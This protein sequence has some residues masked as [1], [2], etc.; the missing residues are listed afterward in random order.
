MDNFVWWFIVI[1]CLFPIWGA[2][3]WHAYEFSI[4]PCLIPKE[5]IDRL[6]MQVLAK[7]DPD[8]AA[9]IEEYAAWH[10][11]DTFEQGRWRRV[12]RELRRGRR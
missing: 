3:L 2:V 11:S 8:A 1:V 7:P 12:R 9:F 5:E 10:R 4:R 6:V